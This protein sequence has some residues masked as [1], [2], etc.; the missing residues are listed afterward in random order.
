MNRSVAVAVRRGFLL[1]TPGLVVCLS[2]SS[3]TIAAESATQSRRVITY[4]IDS[5]D[6]NGADVTQ[7][8]IFD[9][10][11]RSDTLFATISA[12]SVYWDTAETNAEYL[13]GNEL[14][15]VRWEM[16]AQPWP[17]LLLPDYDFV[18]W[19]FNDQSRCWQ[20]MKVKAVGQTQSRNAQLIQPCRAELWQSDRDG[21]SWRLASAE[22]TECDD[23]H[24]YWRGWRA[25]DPPGTHRSASTGLRQLEDAMTVDAWGGKPESIPPP[26]GESANSSNWYYIPCRSLPGRG[27]A[28]RISRRATGTTTFMAP[29]YLL[30]RS[31]GTQQLLETPTIY[32]DQSLWRIGMEEH[33]GFLLVSGIRTYVFDLHTGEQILSQPNA[34]VRHAVW[35]KPPAAASVDSLGLRRLRERFR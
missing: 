14:F 32:R 28:Y 31:K 7:W 16:G 18:D 23:S 19:W 1:A 29:F 15:R 11:T 8:R 6:V 30:D 33:D 25:S 22:T 34:S 10:K 26:R 35:I 5:R 12:H 2:L 27:M 21:A 3:P 4:F 9:P 20:A 13:S 24:T 17:V